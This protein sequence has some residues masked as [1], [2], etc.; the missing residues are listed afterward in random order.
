MQVVWNAPTYQTNS[1]AVA[2]LQLT[3]LQAS[4][5][6]HSYALTVA[7]NTGAAL[8]SAS[9]QTPASAANPFNVAL[10]SPV[11]SAAVYNVTLTIYGESS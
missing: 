5:Q 1:Y 6:S 8:A 2:G 10:G 3:G 11:D 4:C 9:G 7:D